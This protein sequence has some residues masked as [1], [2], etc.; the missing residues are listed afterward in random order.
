MEKYKIMRML[1]M[2]D[3]PVETEEQRRA[4]RIFRKNLIQEGFVMIQYSIYVRICPSREYANRLEN[5]IKKGIPQEGN[6]RLL[7]VTEKQYADMKLLVGSRQTA[8]TAIG[9]ERLIII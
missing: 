1:C 9:T 7:C 8:E 2:F 5:R 3:L 6:V 4:Y